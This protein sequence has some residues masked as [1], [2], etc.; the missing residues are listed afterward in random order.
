MT[1]DD[2]YTPALDE[3][4]FDDDE[5][6]AIN[7]AL[8]TEDPWGWGPNAQAK[9][10]IKS[11]K[12]RICD[13][14]MMRHNELC[15][16]CRVPLHGTG[17][18]TRDREH[19]LPKSMPLYRPLS[20]TMW[21]LGIACKRCNMEYKKD[22]I[23]FLIFPNDMLELKKSANYR[24]IHPNFDRYNEHLSRHATQSDETVVIKYKVIT[25]SAKGAYTY[26]YFN[27]RG[28]EIGSFDRAQGVEQSEGFGEFA[29]EAKR[30]ADR[31]S[32]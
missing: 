21:N 22:R 11:A 1:I 26:N 3:F 23:D 29:L 12:D 24:F 7:A 6:D 27:L 9:A 15:C 28:L 17:P 18:F 2:G 10:R 20:Y 31:F 16:Y 13:Y 25:G 14:H 5:R 19:I 32:Q 30:I 4:A 8:E